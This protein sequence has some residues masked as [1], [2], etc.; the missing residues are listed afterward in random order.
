MIIILNT[1]KGNSMDKQKALLILGPIFKEVFE[2]N[3][4]VINEESNIDNIPNWD[5]LSHIYLVVAIEDA[6]NKKFSAEEIQ[7]WHS[8]KDI[9][10]SILKNSK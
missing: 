1:K 10:L 8:V 6:F 5:S 4:L 7:S 2:E 9:L 3:D